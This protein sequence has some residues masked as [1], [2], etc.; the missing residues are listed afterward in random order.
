MATA[1]ANRKESGISKGGN[2]RPGEIGPRTGVCG[3]V[4][5]CGWTAC[6]FVLFF[7]LCC[8]ADR[9]LSAAG[10]RGKIGTPLENHCFISF[11]TLHLLTFGCWLLAAWQAVAAAALLPWHGLPHAAVTGW[12]HGLS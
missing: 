1:A 8:M 4:V 5:V 9:M 12:G 2:V 6:V 3:R 10:H 11:S 7:S